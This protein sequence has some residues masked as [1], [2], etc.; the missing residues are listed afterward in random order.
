MEKSSSDRGASKVGGWLAEFSSLADPGVFGVPFSHHFPLSSAT[1]GVPHVVIC[2]LTHGNEFGTLPA[3]LRLQKELA[4]GVV[5]P[6]VPVTLLLGNP[7]AALRNERYL[8]EDFNRVM[9]FDRPADNLERKRA[10]QVRPLLDAAD[11]FLDIHQT[12]TPT[13]VPFWT[14]PWEGDLGLWARALGGADAGLT[15]APGGVFS[16][17]KC[18]LD[19]YVRARNRMGITIEVGERGE[20]S[21]Q[22]ERAY[23]VMRRLLDVQTR[24]IQGA[25]LSA[26]AAGMPPI[27]WYVTR[28]VVPALSD[29]HRLR[30]GIFNFSRVRKG[31]LLSDSGAPEIRAIEDG[32]VL[33]PKYPK[34]GEAPPPELFRLAVEVESPD[35]SFGVAS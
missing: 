24:L 18:C 29:A 7:E 17:G 23:G 15:R 13:D 33:F 19:E 14:M 5:R 28:E 2:V 35:A 12:Q 20:D 4:S 9:T 10:E 11:R 8:E 31:E 22:A 16:K 6:E 21:E 32:C 34:L 27:R 1:L 30:P 25:E 3:A 26:E